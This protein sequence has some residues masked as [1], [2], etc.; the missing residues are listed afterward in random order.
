M[1]EHKQVNI[2][3]PVDKEI[4]PIIKFIIKHYAYQIVPYASCQGSEKEKAYISFILRSDQELKG[5]LQLFPQFEQRKEL[6]G[7]SLIIRDYRKTQIDTS[8]YYSIYMYDVRIAWDIIYTPEILSIVN[9][10]V[11]E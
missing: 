5:F 6:G 11:I 9:K 1:N 3:M 8:H 7:Y 2:S 10:F 4:A